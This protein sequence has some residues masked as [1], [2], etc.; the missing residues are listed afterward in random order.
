MRRM[1]DEK[2][3][4]TLRANNQIA[5]SGAV[6]LDVDGSGKILPVFLSEKLCS[7]CYKDEYIRQS[8][9][10]KMEVSEDKS[11]SALPVLPEKV[12]GGGTGDTKE[13][14]LAR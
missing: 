3:M 1:V 14:Y 8:E 2:Y 6:F 5:G 7:N 13:S 12:S 4:E 10:M 11:L 9:I